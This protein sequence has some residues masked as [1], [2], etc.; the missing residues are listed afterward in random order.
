MTDIQKLYSRIPKSSC[1]DGCFDCCT[2]I[3][4]FAREEAERAG[5]YKYYDGLCGFLDENK[6]CTIYDNRP[7][8]C[9]IYGVSEIMKC[10]DCEADRLLSEEE[11]RVIIKEYAKI[12]DEQDRLI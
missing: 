8:V 6:N 9:R 5:E 1:V 11:T 2:S 10:E 7:L 3:I 4:Q 12:K